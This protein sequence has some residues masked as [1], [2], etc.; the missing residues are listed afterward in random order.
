MP[1]FFS[2]IFLSNPIV[3]NHSDR[4]EDFMIKI[5]MISKLKI[6]TRKLKQY[7]FVLYLSYKD[8]RTPWFAKVIALCVVAYAFSPIDLIPDF[9]PVLGY[10]DDLILVPLGILLAMKLIPPYVV[11][12]N[13]EAAEA[14][15]KEEKPKN[16]YVGILI[17]SIWLLLAIWFYN[18]L[19]TFFKQYFKSLFF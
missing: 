5:D 2:C 15:K 3:Y 8:P 4:G 12:E 11:K 14:L 16:W 19:I 1:G 10:V 7:L 9:I 18:Q 6:Y 17:L 13:W